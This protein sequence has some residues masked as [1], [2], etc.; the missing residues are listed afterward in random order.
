MMWSVI[1]EA[2]GKDSPRQQKFT[3][4][5]NLR[6][7]FIT[8]TDSIAINFN[9]YFTEIGP[10]LANKIITPLVNFD[11][12]LNNM[13]KIFQPQ[14][15]LSINKLKDAFYSLKTNKSPGHDDICF[16]II[17]QCFG[18]LNRPLHYIYNISLQSGVLPEEVKIA[19]VTPIFKG[20]EVSD[21]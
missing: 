3:N 13:C 1:K 21:L 9:K 12:Y 11:T 10:N 15:A 2:I 16:N 18:T 4:K 6:S 17:K 20:A 8:S 14:N 19:R 7:K 5:I